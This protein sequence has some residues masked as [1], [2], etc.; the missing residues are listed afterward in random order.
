M[1]I[2]RAAL[3]ECHLWRQS[4]KARLR[5]LVRE[6]HNPLSHKTFKL[7]DVE[8]PY[9]VHPYNHTW[10]NERAVEIPVARYFLNSCRPSPTLEVGN[11]LSH[12]F[13]LGHT[14]VDMAEKC[15]YRPVINSDLIEFFPSQR[16]ALIVSISTIEHVGW[17]ETPRDEEK[18]MSAFSKV[19]SLLTPSGK[20]LV[21]IPVGY[22]HFLDQR[23]REAA[24]DHARFQCLKRVSWDNQWVETDLADALHC[25]YG[26]PFMNANAVVFIHLSG[27]SVA[28]LSPFSYRKSKTLKAD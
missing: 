10:A 26:Y 27:N 20:A 21:T 7:G 6:R 18:V 16:F 9:F 13:D 2:W 4:P 8:L 3:R 24:I 14:V 15:R 12:Y 23:M 28:S 17:D 1:N 19:R 5:W 25:K 22:N 11:V